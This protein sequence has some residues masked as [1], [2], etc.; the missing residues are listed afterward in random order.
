MQI[1]KLAASILS[2]TMAAAL[3]ATG[4]SPAPI[5]MKSS[6]A[7]SECVI[8][9]T[10]EYQT[11]RGFGGINH[12]EWIGDLTESQRQTAFGNGD[13]ELGF[14][15]LRLFVNDD[16][17]QWSKAVATAKAAQ[18]K[19][20]LI[21][22]SPWNPPSSMTEMFDRDGNSSNGNE[23]KRLR[24]DK[25]AEYAEHLNDFVKFMKENGVDVYA[26][27]IQNEPDYG[28]EWTWWTSDE[29]LDFLENYADKIDCRI[30][31]PETFQYNKEYYNKI[32]NS[33]KA[34]S[35]VDIFAT[36]FYGVARSSMDFPALEKC[37][38]EI[39]MTEVYVP[40]SDQN[41]ADR[42][43]EALQ[44]S[45]NIHNGLA[46]GNMSAYVWW[47]IRRHYG[48]MKDD[49]TIS[50]RGYCMAQY[51]KYVRPGDVRI[52]ATEKPDE[53]VYVSAYKND[54]NQVTVVAV[55]MG[56]TDVTQD[57]TVGSG[58]T[59]TD[60]DSYRTSKDEN[61]AF[62][63]I[64][65]FSGSDYSVNLPGESVSTFV[66]SIEGEGKPVVPKE[67]ETDEDGYYFHDTF[68]NDTCGWKGR[69]AASVDTVNW[70]SYKD[71]QALNVTARTSKWH[72]TYKELNSEVF[73]AGKS[74]SFS[75]AVRV[76]EN[77]ADDVIS[78]T[79]QYNDA[80]G[81]TQYP[82]IVS[83]DAEAGKYVVLSTDSFTIPEDASGLQIYVETYN[84]TTD[85]SID[86]A[87]GAP[88]GA[89]SGDSAETA[90]DVNN[91]GKFD[92]ADVVLMQRYLLNDPDAK[93]A[94]WKSGDFFKDILFD[95]SD[96]SLMI[97][98]LFM[99]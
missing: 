61:L 36:H 83:A 22:A 5:S 53:S 95:V 23:A 30:I 77:A 72:G 9:T 98:M 89:F 38:K 31:S 10:T 8:D 20:A 57:F 3:L 17:T 92:V 26:I 7:S 93:L 51:S 58:E 97:Q 11:I 78:L 18:E 43:P 24:H 14:S 21:F 81:V 47:Y 28:S 6:A 19:G 63:D 37:G 94:N 86:E 84:T 48:P 52:A 16:R 70:T 46:V 90:G 49:G 1:K 75:V 99:K 76:P 29:C 71:S 91:D 4:I 68:E 69:G 96:L 87:I 35:N 64:T 15:I 67:P 54:N 12:P 34:F 27:S 79:L 13:N 25:Y 45:E 50:K 41:S 2:C 55:N 33:E 66:I 32:L 88:A 62:T 40:N 85:F 80:E 82:S 59:I 42:W 56:T 44:V 60:I 73:K 65:D 74:Y 39:W